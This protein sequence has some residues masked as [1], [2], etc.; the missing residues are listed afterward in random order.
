M[1]L[2]NHT[3][4]QPKKTAVGTFKKQNNSVN[5]GSVMFL[6]AL[7][8]FYDSSYFCLHWHI[9]L[10]LS[11][12]TGTFCR[13]CAVTLAHSTK[14]VQLHWHI[15]LKLCSVTLA[16]STGTVQLHSHILLKLCSY[17]GTLLKLCS[18]TGTFY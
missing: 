6:F 17:T 8:S 14:D 10:E 7:G 16:L 3:I 15:L 2:T 5:I 12:H 4:N 1:F 18:Y 9:L 13:S 11:S